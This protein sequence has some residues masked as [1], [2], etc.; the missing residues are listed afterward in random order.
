M[1]D[2]IVMEDYRNAPSGIGPLAHEWR[3]KPHR[4]VYDLCSEIERLR[5]LVAIGDDLAYWLE[6]YATFDDDDSRARLH[7]KVWKHYRKEANR[8]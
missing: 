7:I 4:L 3:N 1:T 2:D 6:D 8:D 5:A